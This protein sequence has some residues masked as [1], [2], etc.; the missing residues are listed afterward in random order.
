MYIL[1]PQILSPAPG[2]AVVAYADTPTESAITPASI[3]TAQVEPIK[4]ITYDGKK[5]KP[6][7]KV[8][9]GDKQLKKDRDYTVTYKNNKLPGKATMIIKSK[10]PNYTGEIKMGFNIIVQTPK[11]FKLTTTTDSVQ[12]SW[13][14]TSGK[15]TGYTV[16]RAANA[17][18]TKAKIMKTITSAKTRSYSIDRPYYKSVYYVKVRAYVKIGGKKYYSSYTDAKVKS[19]KVASWFK[20]ISNDIDKK[21]KWIEADLSKQI[22]YLHEGKTIVKRY[23]VSSGRPGTPTLR[24]TFRVYKKIKLHDMRGDWDPVKQEWGYVTPNVKWATYFKEGYA[25]HGSY[26]N[27][28]VNKP[29]D[30]KRT[31][32]SHGCV[33]MR[34]KD[35][36]YL[37]RWAPIGTFVVV[38]K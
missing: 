17:K 23:A 32:R 20:K 24:G 4:D 14:K 35:A 15:V 25:F 22:V 34:E 36:K 2:V 7:P 13:K 3:S 29:I 33:N 26:W 11:G 27:P 19:T 6:S 16:V 9:L 12:A 37:Y 21:T 1:S 30:E 28:E 31:P 18:F 38:H 8:M 10:A 5:K